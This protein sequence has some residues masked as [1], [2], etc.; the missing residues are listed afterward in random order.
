M[1]LEHRRRQ[2]RLCAIGGFAGAVGFG[3]H[4]L[5][6]V[7]RLVGERLGIGGRPFK[8][9]KLGFGV[10]LDLGGDRLDVDVFGGD[11]RRLKLL[12]SQLHGGDGVGMI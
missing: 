1:D 10:S 7:L 2:A 6:L 4:A 9:A 11:A 3:P 8:V 5:E 12:D